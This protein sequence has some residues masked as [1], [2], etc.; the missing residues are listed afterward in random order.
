MKASLCEA[1]KE[2][3]KKEPTIEGDKDGKREGGGKREKEKRRGKGER[4]F[5]LVSYSF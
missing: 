4:R 5:E 2:R 1:E 3:G